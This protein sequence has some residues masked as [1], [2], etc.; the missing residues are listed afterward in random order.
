MIL[1]ATS[2]LFVIKFGKATEL[3]SLSRIGC[4]NFD[5]NCD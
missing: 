5:G 4:T 1:K 3:D 2:Q